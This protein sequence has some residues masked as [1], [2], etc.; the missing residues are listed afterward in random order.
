ML[1]SKHFW[2]GFLLAYGVAVFFP[3][4]KLFGKKN[5]G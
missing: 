5:Q 3:P 4:Q 2:I 1:T